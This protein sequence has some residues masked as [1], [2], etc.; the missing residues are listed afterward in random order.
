MTKME[1]I[2]QIQS[3]LAEL[4][5]EQAQ[6]LAELAAAWSRP[7]AAEDDETRA[8]IAE[9]LAQAR[10]GEFA[11]PADVDALLSRPWK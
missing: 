6:A 1:A 3:S 11:S 2:A 5:A 9:G 10:R 7:I 4:S 8:A